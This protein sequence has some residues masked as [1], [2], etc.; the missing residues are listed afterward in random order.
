M[1]HILQALP[2]SE[3]ETLLPHLR[4]AEFDRGVSLYDAG[5]PVHQVLFPTSCLVSSVVTMEN[6]GTIE[7]SLVGREGVSASWMLLGA[8]RSPWDCIIQMSGSAYVMSADDFGACLVTMPTLRRAVSRH[9]LDEHHLASQ[10]VGC[11]RFHGLTE[12]TAR[13]LLTVMDRSGVTVFA[14]TREFLG[15]MI[16]AHRPSVS[17]ALG[18]LSQAGLIAGRRGR[19]EILDPAGLR[20]AACECYGRVEQFLARPG[21]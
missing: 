9:V 15:Q 18:T 19:I 21:A 13:W 6:G 1:N 8:S 3:L 11:N 7:V 20:E 10:S 2:E 5:R 12:R 17:V 14:L 4:E 16:G